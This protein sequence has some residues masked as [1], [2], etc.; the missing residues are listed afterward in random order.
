VPGD[1]E[2][3]ECLVRERFHLGSVGFERASRVDADP[4]ALPTDERVIIGVR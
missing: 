3:R 4:S 1:G 2:L